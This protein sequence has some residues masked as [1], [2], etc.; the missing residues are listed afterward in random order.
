[1]EKS[2][3]KWVDSRSV[4]HIFIYILIYYFLIYNYIFRLSD[5]EDDY[6]HEIKKSANDN[7]AGL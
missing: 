2:I 7:Y 4:N 5:E 3:L 1:M 6:R